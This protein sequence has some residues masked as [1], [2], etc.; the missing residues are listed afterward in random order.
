MSLRK[1]SLM[2]TVYGAPTVQVQKRK[3]YY[4]YICRI[5]NKLNSAN[6]T[7]N[8]LFLLS[9]DTYA[10][11]KTARAAVTV[12]FCAFVVQDTESKPSSLLL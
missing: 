5:L 12:E 1:V 10:Y 4:R 8:L 6:P 7:E 9:G 2:L 11:F 3:S